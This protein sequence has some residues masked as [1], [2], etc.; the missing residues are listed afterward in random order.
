VVAVVDWDVVADVVWE[1]VTLDVTVVVWD[2]VCELVTV[3]VAV[4][5]W[6]VVGVVD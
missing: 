6:E 5:V 3:V 4:V 2:V 1:L